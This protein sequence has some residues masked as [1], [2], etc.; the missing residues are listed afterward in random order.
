M[1]KTRTA[2][3]SETPDE[4]ASGKTKYEEKR[5]KQKAQRDKESLKK[6]QVGKVGLKGGERIKVIGADI[7]DALQ[8]E[9]SSAKAM[10]EKEKGVRPPRKRGKKY[11]ESQALVDK[12]KL[13]PLTDAIKL[14]KKTSYSKFDGTV[15]LHLVV[16][17]L[18]TIVNVNLPYSAGKKKKVEVADKK[19]LEK[20]KKGKIDFDIL[21]VDDEKDLAIIGKEFEWAEMYSI[22][23]E[24]NKRF[25]K[26]LRVLDITLGK[27]EELDWGDFVYILGFPLS[28]KMVSRAIVSSPNYDKNHSFI[29]DAYLQKGISGG[30]VLAIRDGIPNLEFVGIARGVSGRTEYLVV[31]E[32][33]D[34]PSVWELMK[35]Y[36]GKI[37]R[38]KH[39]FIEPGM[40]YTISIESIMT[41]IDDHEN[42]LKDK[43]YNSKLFL[44]RMNHQ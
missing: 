6:K 38:K 2:F 26:P 36:R 16:K 7:T 20:L 35:P 15:E 12:T 40:T 34:K 8:K 10:E 44:N 9:P 37:F 33:E 1:G 18:G 13:Y 27:A 31:P 23:Q 28:K 17:K 41:F 5:K 42:E 22:Q 25:N 21:L 39:E 14:V 30:I 29:L 3:I 24:I 11:T 32:I 4:K 19:T 43:G